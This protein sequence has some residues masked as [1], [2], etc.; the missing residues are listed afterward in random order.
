[1]G[2]H[3]IMLEFKNNPQKAHDLMESEQSS[4]EPPMGKGRN[5]KEIKVFLEFNKNEE[6]TY[7]NL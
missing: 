7:P 1:M 2:H 3:G 5:K 4:T 6:T